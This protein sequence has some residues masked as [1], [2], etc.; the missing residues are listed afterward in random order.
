MESLAYS[1]FGLMALAACLFVGA[2]LG[3]IVG[4]VGLLV[5]R[6][7]A[8]QDKPLLTWLF[9]GLVIISGMI[10]LVM[11]YGNFRLNEA[12]SEFAAQS[13]T[14][15]VSYTPQHLNWNDAEMTPFASALDAVDR[16]SLG[17]T[18]IPPC[19]RVEIQRTVPPAEYDVML[20][21]YADTSRTIAFR[22]E[23]DGY[24]WVGEQ[25]VHTGPNQYRSAD[26]YF[27][28]EIVVTF[29]TVYMSGAPLNTL[30]IWYYGDDPRLDGKF[31]LTLRDI[32][33]ILEEWKEAR[34]TPTPSV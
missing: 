24:V 9:A 30:H 34:P 6:L 29:D 21:I 17:F 10:L 7:K 8:A 3:L 4:G 26:G 25:E 2:L 15:F 5:L 22:E 11:I 32:Q 14:V 13:A 1:V 20:H 33:P 31:N 16:A 19:A 18:P 28:E 27:F 12:V 23:Q